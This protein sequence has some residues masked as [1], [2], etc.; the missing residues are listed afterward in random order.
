MLPGMYASAYI[1]LEKRENVPCVPVAALGT[2]GVDSVLYTS[3]DAESGTL[4]DPV[5]VSIG[6]SD[7]ENVQ[8]LEG[9]AAGETCYY[10][11]VDTYV[12]SDSP[13]QQGRGFNF[14][15]MLGG[16]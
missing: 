3:Y 8:I 14:G 6:V 16:R 5:V 11:Y 7:G 10:E 12:G 15:R 2:D 13:Q 9:F 4:G 1:T